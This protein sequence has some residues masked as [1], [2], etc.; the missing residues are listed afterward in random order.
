[1]NCKH[2]FSPLDYS[3]C[4]TCLKC[5]KC[6]TE[7]DLE[8]QLTAA[9]DE[10]AAER[11][12]REQAK[13]DTFAGQTWVTFDEHMKALKKIKRGIDIEQVLEEFSKNMTAK[14]LHPVIKAI[15]SAAIMPYNNDQDIQRYK[16]LYLDKSSKVADHIIK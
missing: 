13:T 9:R 7:I 2:E 4:A 6:R 1:M 12:K 11:E 5:K 15:Q 16:E 14:L 8:S 10:L 3:N